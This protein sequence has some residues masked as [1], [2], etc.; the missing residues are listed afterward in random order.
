MDERYIFGV[1]NNILVNDLS[2]YLCQ[3][4]STSKFVHTRKHPVKKLF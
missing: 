3:H 2:I 4:L 1:I